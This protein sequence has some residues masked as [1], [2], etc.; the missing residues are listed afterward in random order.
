MNNE[1]I[2]LMRQDHDFDFVKKIGSKSIAY[3]SQHLR[4]MRAMYGR[5]ATFKFRTK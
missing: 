5:R 1:F 2:D 3:S 4:K